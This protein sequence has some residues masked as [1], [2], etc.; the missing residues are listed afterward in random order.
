MNT[1]VVEPGIVRPGDIAAKGHPADLSSLAGS[2]VIA[3]KGH[4][5]DRRSSQGTVGKSRE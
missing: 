2:A 1:R 4:P 3:A 5:A